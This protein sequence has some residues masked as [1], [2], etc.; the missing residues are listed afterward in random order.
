MTEYVWRSP[1][2]AYNVPDEFR[3]KFLN[4][5]PGYRIRWS[6]KESNWH[7]EQPAGRGALPPFRIDPADDSLIRAKDGYW[8]VMK[9][10]PGDR[11]ACPA[12]VERFPLQTCGWTLKVPFRK[13]AETRCENCRK[14][15]RDG[16]SFA[17][18]W[19]FDESLLEELRRTDPLRDGIRRISA[20]ADANNACLAA[21]GERRA[22]D[23]VTSIDSVD[24]RWISGI[25]SSTGLKRRTIDEKDLL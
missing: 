6:L 24:Y 22:S 18:Y 7:I 9:I 1:A 25:P 14:A 13:T 23:A 2:G 19:Y 20:E 16:R 8:G 5:F 3:R 10:Q 21:E 15:G 12:V 4:E 17:G 11:M